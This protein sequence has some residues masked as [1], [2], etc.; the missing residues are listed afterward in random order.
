MSNEQIIRAWKDSSYRDRLSDKE[1]AQLPEN[2][3]GIVELTS[4][5]MM[6]DER[7]MDIAEVRSLPSR[8]AVILETNPIPI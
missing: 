6:N 3:A 8:L 4:S 1:K 5:D 2:P 7:V